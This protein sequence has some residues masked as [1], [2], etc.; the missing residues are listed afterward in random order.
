MKKFQGASFFK[1]VYYTYVFLFLMYLLTP[2]LITAILAFNDNSA[3]SFPWKGFTFRWFFSNTPGSEGVF[4][5]KRMMDAI[6]M[7][8]KVAS[9]VTVLATLL[10]ISNAFLFERRD[11]FGKQFLYLLMLLPLII[12]GVV[13]GISIL[14][15]SHRLSSFFNV[16]FGRKAGSFL[17]PGYWLVVFGQMSFITTLA[18]LVITARLRRFDR[19]LEEAAMDLGANNMTAVILITLRFLAPAIF[20]AAVV[21]FLFSFN[22]FNTTYFLIGT[23]PTLPVLLYSRLRFG[24]TPQINAVSV[25]LMFVT[26][27]LGLLSVF[28]SGEKKQIRQK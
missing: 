7:S 14:S 6:G 1:G 19:T 27:L 5:E 8:L 20:N 12:P 22:N 16:V 23:E 24:I 9:M 2:L 11:F 3:V 10:G 17:N 25:M 4:G 18:T 21:A 26:G 15:F 13:L 28:S